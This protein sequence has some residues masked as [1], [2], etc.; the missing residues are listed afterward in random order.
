[1][2]TFIKTASEAAAVQAK[3]AQTQ[4]AKVQQLLPVNDDVAEV[5]YHQKYYGRDEAEETKA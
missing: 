2:F 3:A 4:S 1:M 5:K